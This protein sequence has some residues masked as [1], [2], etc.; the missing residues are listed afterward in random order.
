[1]SV[2]LVQLRFADGT[3]AVAVADDSGAWR[4]E[5]V[6]STYELALAAIDR[7]LTIEA[8]ARQFASAER[9]DLDR[10]LDERR[11]IAPIDHPDSAHLHLTGT[12]LTHL[13]SAESRDRM[14]RE[15]AT[16]SGPTDSMRMFLLGLEGGKPRNGEVGVQPEWFY[17]GDGSSVVAPGAPLP[18]PDFALDGSEEPEIAGIYVIDADGRPRRLGYCLANEF[19]DHVTE[20]GN[21]LWLAH[22]KLR[23]AALGPELLTGELPRD[24]RGISRVVREGRT[25]WEMPFLTG[26][27]N[28]SHALGNLEHHHFK[29]P[30]FRRPG[31]VHV[32]F[33][34]TATLSFAAGI[35]VQ[36]GDVFEIEAQ[37]FR[38]PLRNAVTRADATSYAV[39]PL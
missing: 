7:D 33:F 12:G 37:P 19:S 20:R 11:V 32:H 34:G 30:L 9:I 15:A 23:P 14:H 17:K 26:E 31:D 5:G 3:R 8:M 25:L 39:Q 21:Y 10:A 36:V 28:M 2:R 22:S 38:L 18:S 35:Q 6:T 13:G 16:A 4:L 24:V 1:M 27:A 29:Y